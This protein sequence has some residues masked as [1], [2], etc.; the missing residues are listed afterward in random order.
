M[1]FE[2]IDNSSSLNEL[3][4]NLRAELHSAAVMVT[5]VGD[6]DQHVLAIG[7]MSMPAEFQDS[8]PLDHSIC[9]HTKAMD[10]PLAI[11]DTVS[12]P[13]LRN[14]KA[15]SNLGV[16]SYVGAPIHDRQKSIGAVCAVELK[17]NFPFVGSRIEQ[18]R[19]LSSLRVDSCQVRGFVEIA[20]WEAPLKTS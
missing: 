13:L 1:Q 11:D 2:K 6:H 7:G 18:A 10:F 16:T 3:V 8:M 20:E 12:H 17:M 4:A 15:F 5:I 14:N 19:D 9:Q